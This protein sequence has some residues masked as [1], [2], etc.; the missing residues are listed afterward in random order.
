MRQR[1]I[2]AALALLALLVSGCA[3][4][5]VITTNLEAPL[6]RHSACS[7]GAII[8]ELPADTEASKKPSAEAIQK[9]KNRI[10]EQIY[11]QRVFDH[12]NGSDSAV[13]EV[14]GSI[15]EYAKG[16]G[17]LRFFIGFGAGSA[18]ITT[19]LKMTNTRTGQ[20]IF[21]GNFKGEVSNWGDSGDKM[22]E[23]VAKAFAKELRKQQKKLIEPQK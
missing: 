17:A 19:N 1:F 12:T 14:T 8:D 23:Q 20:T 10:Q 15:L 3:K 18:K 4:N 22:F 9:F 5:Y 13:Y 16:S 6:A 11:D 21:A 7:V 2:V